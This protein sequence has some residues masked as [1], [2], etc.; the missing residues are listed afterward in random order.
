MPTTR[1]RLLDLLAARP[2]L[3]Q[4]ELAARVPLSTRQAR[5]HLTALEAEGTVVATADGPATR[6]RLA[7]GAHPA[8][9]VPRFTDD[10]AEA[11]A[12]A[13]RAARPLLAPTPLAAPLAAAADKLQAA[14]LADVVSFEPDA[15][16]ALWSFDGA[17]GGVTAG[18]DPDAFRALLTAAR[19]RHAV[20]ADYFTAS[21]QA[22]T[23]GRTLAPL[24]LLVRSGAWL[25]ACQDLDAEPGP[26]G[27]PVKD[28]ALAGFR[29]ATPLPDRPAHPAPAWDP[30]AHA[31]DR[32]GALDGDP[33]TVRLL[34]SPEAAPYFRRKAYSRTQLV[35][36]EHAGGA[37]TVSFETA[38]LDDAR[39]FVMGW[40]ALVRVL[41][42]PALADAVAQAHREAANLYAD[43]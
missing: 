10:E 31:A 38:G 8:T 1:D 36:A 43:S 9:P 6:Y 23:R 42:P 40:G 24:A 13:A 37:L 29:A 19:G 22:L 15:D 3:A 28:F 11:L 35:E 25:A 20:R 33:E 21:R 12:V 18:L 5:R 7:D 41:D 30:D 4:A 34:V 26:D 39:A 27:P 16:A 2:G 14:A 32:L 17:A